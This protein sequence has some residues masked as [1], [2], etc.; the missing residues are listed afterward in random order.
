MSHWK[1]RSTTNLD[2]VYFDYQKS[3]Q[4]SQADLAYVWDLD[5]TYLDTT[6]DSIRGLFYTV[7]EK[8]FTKKNVPGTPDLIR[9]L[10]RY[11]KKHFNEDDFPLFFVSASPP[12]MESK[13]YEKFVLD[14]IQPIGMFYKDNLRNLAPKKL[15]FLRKQIGY[16]VQS[17]LQ[18]RTKLSKNVKM[19]CF[20]DDSESDATIYNL[21]SD[22]C[23]R[24]HTETQL[25]TLLDDL[26]VNYAQIDE[27]LRLQSE[28]NI[29]DPVEKIYINLATDTDPEYYLKYGRRTLATYNS[30]QVALDLVQDQRLSLEE[31]GFIADG[32]IEKYG[33]TGD[34]LVQTF[35]ELI[36]RRIL[37]LSSYEMIKNYFIEKKIIPQSWN[38]KIEPLREKTV[39][40][41]HVY[42]LEG[43]FEPWIPR[44]IDYLKDY[45]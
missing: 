21:F 12:Q 15:L 42:E 16:K 24:R 13:V 45:R 2:V 8:A 31:L 41:G 27:I 44:Q 43:I 1:Q 26:S 17:L 38:S 35:E 34:L 39:D 10:S 23:A 22:I 18:L 30:F 3:A 25:T 19:I 7:F 14:E 4:Y 5:K 6:I 11:R 40:N 20:G 37:G 29:Q 36:R 32:L 33:F 28:I 9:S